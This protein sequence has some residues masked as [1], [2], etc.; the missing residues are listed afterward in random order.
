M[1]RW[2]H[3][4][5][6]FSSKLRKRELS[7]LAIRGHHRV[8]AVRHSQNALDLDL[9][10]L[11]VCKAPPEFSY[12]GWDLQEESASPSLQAAV[13]KQDDRIWFRWDPG[14]LH[15]RLHEQECGPAD[16][17]EVSKWWNRIGRHQ[18]Q[19]I[20]IRLP[21]KSCLTVLVG[22]VHSQ[23]SGVCWCRPRYNWS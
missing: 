19:T 7:I 6:R 13:D 4:K 11:V 23:S 3:S 16:S 14:P 22:R 9:A 17:S 8:L 1:W 20:R 15:W 5:R 18:H 2:I 10:I 12:L 21:Q